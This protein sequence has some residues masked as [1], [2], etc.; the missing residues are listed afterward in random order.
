MLYKSILHYPKMLSSNAVIFFQFTTQHLLLTSIDPRRVLGMVDLCWSTYNVLI[1]LNEY[2][3]M[4]ERLMIWAGVLAAYS[5]CILLEIQY[6]VGIYSVYKQSIMYI[7]IRH[8][9]KYSQ[10]IDRCT[11]SLVYSS[12]ID[13]RCLLKSF[14]FVRC[15]YY[16]CVLLH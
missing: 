11:W 16:I 12:N 14:R 10:S 8:Y 15:N 3:I 6:L 13:F 4:P 1:F 5:D 9:I 2:H 7:R